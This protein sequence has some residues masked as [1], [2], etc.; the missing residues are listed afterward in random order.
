[1]GIWSS[2]EVEAALPKQPKEPL[3]D[4]SWIT[5]K[6]VRG[7]RNDQPSKAGEKA[8]ASRVTLPGRV[9]Q[10]PSM[11]SSI[12]TRSPDMPRRPG[13]AA[14]TFSRYGRFRSPVRRPES[15]AA[16]STG[17]GTPKHCTGAPRGCSIVETSPQHGTHLRPQPRWNRATQSVD[18]WQ[19]EPP[20][21]RLQPVVDHV[22][23]DTA[24]ESLVAFDE[25]ELKREAVASA[26]APG[27]EID[28]M[29]IRRGIR[30]SENRGGR[31]WCGARHIDRQSQRPG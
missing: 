22:L 18:P 1:M 21:P 26:D 17:V 14:M 31:F 24:L 2:A 25:P 10:M 8:I 20:L 19:K 23:R 7:N 5:A 27:D 15:S 13:E 6:L 3:G 16:S 28:R 11:R 9:A 29:W 4:L 12:S 30:P